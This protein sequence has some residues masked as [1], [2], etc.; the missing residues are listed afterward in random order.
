MTDYEKLYNVYF[1]IYIAHEAMMGAV[2][3][4]CT[5][6]P[7]VDLMKKQRASDE[8]LIEEELNGG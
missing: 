4:H 5:H 7:T 6:K 3:A 1:S 8:R 2:M